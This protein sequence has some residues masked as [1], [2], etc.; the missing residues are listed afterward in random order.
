MSIFPDN[1][2][3][4]H[5]KKLSASDRRVLN[6][7]ASSFFEYANT[8]TEGPAQF[9]KAVLLKFGHETY[10][11]MHY[12]ATRYNA[13]NRSYVLDIEYCGSD[14]SYNL[15][16]TSG[17]AVDVIDNNFFSKLYCEYVREHPDTVE[18]ING[19]Y[20]DRNAEIISKLPDKPMEW[21]R[22]YQY[23]PVLVL[24]KFPAKG[25]FGDFRREFEKNPIIFLHDVNANK[26]CMKLRYGI[27]VSCSHENPVWRQ[28]KALSVHRKHDDMIVDDFQSS[29]E[30]IENDFSKGDVF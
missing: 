25:T 17:R 20:L 18:F 22:D 19:E 3:K 16:A 4:H 28:E 26:N 7:E 23:P 21:A 15:I 13:R 1:S 8:F 6:R 2:D 30:S 12:A 10:D 14:S 11:A 27:D 9:N 29:S 5:N 24:S